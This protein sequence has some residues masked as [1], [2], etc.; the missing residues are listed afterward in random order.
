MDLEYVLYENELKLS[1]W[2]TKT[3]YRRFLQLAFLSKHYQL[4]TTGALVMGYGKT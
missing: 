1:F 4:G 2:S 3:A